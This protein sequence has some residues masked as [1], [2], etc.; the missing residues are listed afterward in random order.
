MFAQEFLKIDNQFV[1]LTKAMSYLQNSGKLA[2][3]VSEIVKEYVL[4]QELAKIELAADIVEK[5][6]EEFCQFNQRSLFR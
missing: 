5:T 1:G 2:N 3:F 6:I 4:E